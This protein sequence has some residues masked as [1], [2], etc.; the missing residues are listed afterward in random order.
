[1]T[2]KNA[3]R[4]DQALACLKR[5]KLIDDELSGL[6]QQMLKLDSQEHALQSLKFQATT[7]GVERAATAAIRAKLKELGTI[8]G[9]EKQREETEETLEDAYEMLGLAAQPTTIP[10]L[11]QDEDELWAELEAMEE[12]EEQKQMTA[13][14]TTVDL[15]AVGPSA[16][17]TAPTPSEQ[18]E[19]EL[20]QL[21][22]LAA[23]MR[24]E[25]APMPML[26]MAAGM[27]VQVA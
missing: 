15:G 19:R 14:L 17:P 11:G 2:H 7:S 8:E 4:K 12:V 13:K 26:G 1:M 24:V 16:F 18:E 10:G 5:K 3:G 25:H 9:L 23:S 20:A 6:V 22:Q 21:E 27:A